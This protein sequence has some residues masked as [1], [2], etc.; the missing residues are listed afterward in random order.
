MP[1]IRQKRRHHDFIHNYLQTSRKGYLQ[2][3]SNNLQFI[4]GFT[5][6]Y[7]L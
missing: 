1:E 3:T 6:T 4:Q 2:L 7:S 5:L